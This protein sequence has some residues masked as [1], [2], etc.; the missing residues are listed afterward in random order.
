MK[1]TKTNVLVAF[2]ALT[3]AS[4]AFASRGVKPKENERRSGRT[5]TQQSERDQRARDLRQNLQLV[6]NISNGYR[7]LNEP[8]LRELDLKPENLVRL[9]NATARAITD[10]LLG[11]NGKKVLESMISDPSPANKAL[12]TNIQLMAAKNLLK[13]S[14][15]KWEETIEGETVRIDSMD[16]LMGEALNVARTGSESFVSFLALKSKLEKDGVSTKDAIK[17]ALTLLKISYED[18]VKLCLKRKA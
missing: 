2:L 7:I 3:V 6:Q 8:S 11:A 5:E 14:N 9:N 17:Q 1:L 18:F 16:F 13:D 10:G 15:T 4:S 12:F